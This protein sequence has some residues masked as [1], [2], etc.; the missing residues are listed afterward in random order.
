MINQP[1][2]VIEEE[3]ITARG[4]K[5]VAENIN[6][7]QQFK[8]IT[9]NVPQDKAIKLFDY[10]N[11]SYLGE[12]TNECSFYKRD[13]G[14]DNIEETATYNNEYCLMYDNSGASM[15]EY[16]YIYKGG[17]W[18]VSESRGIPQSMLGNNAY[19]IGL[20]Y[21]SKFEKVTDHKDYKNE[22]PS[23]S[24]VDMLG[25][26]GKALKQTLGDSGSMIV[27]G[28]QSKDKTN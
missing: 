1:W 7:G 11:C 14:R 15:I 20:V 3:G 18:H 24:E 22:K 2:A 21:W 10:G 8:V 9:L 16:I 27:Q 12:T 25:Q 26:I 5:S 13:W 6:K 28:M 4:T 19:D 17:E 23:M